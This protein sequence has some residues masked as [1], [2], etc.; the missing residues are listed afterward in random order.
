MSI[1]WADHQIIRPPEKPKDDIKL[2]ALSENI[3]K[4]LEAVKNAVKEKTS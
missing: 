2:E 3:V 1:M 4:A